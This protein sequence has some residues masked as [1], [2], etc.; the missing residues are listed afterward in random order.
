MTD[1]ARNDVYSPNQNEKRRL[2]VWAWYPAQPTPGTAE[3]EYLPGK[4]V[5][6]DKVY[7]TSFGSAKLRSHSFGNAAASSSRFPVLVF[8]PAGFSP[9]SYSSITEDLAS[10][11]YAVIGIN[12]TYDAPVTVFKDGSVL[13]VS[14]R[15]MEEINSRSIS[16]QESFG[17]RSQ[18]A[19]TKLEDIIFVTNELENLDKENPIA[20]HLDTG[21]IGVFGHSLGG[22]AALEFCLIDSRCKCA[23]NM[24]GAIWTNVGAMGTSKPSMI[25]AADHPEFR[26]PCDLL[27]KSHVFPSIE[28]CEAERKLLWDG[29]KRIME[30]AIP[31]YGFTIENSKHVNFVD[32]Q[33]VPLSADSPFKAVMGSID[34]YTMSQTVREYL[35]AFFNKY[36]KGMT[37]RL[38]DRSTRMNGVT[39]LVF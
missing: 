7:H 13:P 29:W 8:S 36:V 28:W 35:L 4:W 5:G 17:F 30:T 22:N 3:A 14:Q 33:F 26:E 12:H 19:N 38:L 16:L 34:P 2:V 15:F 1:K 32:V 6:A 9:L 10:H 21:R 20:N 23:V 18:A 24:D 37:N 31:A 25:L 39:P 27:V 11:G